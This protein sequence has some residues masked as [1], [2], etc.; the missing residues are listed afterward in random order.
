MGEISIQGFNKKPVRVVFENAQRAIPFYDV[1]K[2]SINY[3]SSGWAAESKRQFAYVQLLKF[4]LC[5]FCCSTTKWRAFS[6]IIKAELRISNWKTD[7]INLKTCLLFLA[8]SWE[9]CPD[10]AN[11]AF[12]YVFVLSELARSIAGSIR[13]LIF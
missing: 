2:I 7:R 3:I 5:G 12:N 13:S 10:F 11:S 1:V 9:R 8:K 6:V 4:N